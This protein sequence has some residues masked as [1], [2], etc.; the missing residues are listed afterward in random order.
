MRGYGMAYNLI[1]HAIIVYY[2]YSI[3]W[4]SIQYGFLVIDAC[5]MEG[6]PS[7]CLLYDVLLEFVESFFSRAVF[8]GCP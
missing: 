6:I 8:R 1:S 3:S 2:I 5:S 4:E 7:R